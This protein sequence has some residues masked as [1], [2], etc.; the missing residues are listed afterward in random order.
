MNGSGVTIYDNGSIEGPGL[1]VYGP[2]QG[3]VTQELDETVVTISDATGRRRL[4]L[5]HPRYSLA[6]DAPAS[7]VPG[8]AAFERDLLAALQAANQVEQS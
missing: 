1:T 8:R 3:R 2:R 7:G 4:P 5:P 6:S